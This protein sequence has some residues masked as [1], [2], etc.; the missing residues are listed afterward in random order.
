LDADSPG[1]GVKLPCRFTVSDPVSAMIV[2]MAQEK[3]RGLQLS[4][5]AIDQR[6][7]QAATFELA[8]AALSGAFLALESASWDTKRWAAF[9]C[10][11]FVIGA[12][13]AFLGVWVGKQQLAGVEPS[14]WFRTKASGPDNVSEARAWI[15][16]YLEDA[17]DANIK[18]DKWR[19]RGLNASLLCAV[20]GGM[21][22][23]AA[24][25]SRLCG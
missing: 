10:L 3:V 24:A 13:F 1:Q 23:T 14:Y 16:G 17:I 15:A 22:V 5:A 18:Q 19:S 12:F 8:A 7:T 4:G 11:A 6:C 9:S 20:I 25:F 21:F 2:E